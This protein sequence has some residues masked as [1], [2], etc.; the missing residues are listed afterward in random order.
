MQTTTSLRP[1]SLPAGDSHWISKAARFLT[2]WHRDRQ[3]RR[4]LA[5]IA[6]TAPHL[7]AD[8]GFAPGRTRKSWHRDGL[9]ITIRQ[10]PGQPPQVTVTTD[11][12]K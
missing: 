11:T 6:E 7:L 8:A 10:A 9:H 2:Q 12:P 3:M 1:V 5:R 4:D